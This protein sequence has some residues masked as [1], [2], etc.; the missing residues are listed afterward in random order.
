MTRWWTADLHYNHPNINIY[1]NRPFLK[2]CDLDIHGKWVS[3]EAAFDCAERGNMVLTRNWN[4][5][6]K[7]GDNGVIVG[8]LACKGGEKGV[9]SLH[10]PVSE[11]LSNLNG[12]ITIVEG[13]HDANN[14]VKSVCDFM[15]VRI[16]KMRVGV[17]H[18]PLQDER[19]FNHWNSLSNDMK[20]IK[21]WYGTKNVQVRQIQFA[22]AQYCR[23][24]FKF[25]ICGHV[26]NAWHYKYI[27]GILHINVGV[28][29]NRFMPINDQEILNIY[30]KATKVL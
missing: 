13:N 26:H 16:G 3:P 22:H 18:I 17:Q 20:K 27:A 24:N 30:Y 15:S 23:D 29:V 6:V 9:K 11:I 7:P 28:D 25:I 2:E 21:P 14:G 5:R 4:M 8:D 10:V 1:S 19:A 12:N